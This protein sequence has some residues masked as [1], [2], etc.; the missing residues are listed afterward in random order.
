MLELHD[1]AEG[2]T[3]DIPAGIQSADT[4][5]NER[6]HMRKFSWLGIYLDPNLDLFDSYDIYKDFLD[7]SS[8]TA[9]IAHDLDKLDI[10]IQGSSILKSDAICNRERIE[11]L[12]N[13]CE[14]LITTDQVRELLP[15]A[16][17]M[18]V[19]AKE[20]FGPSNSSVKNYY[21]SF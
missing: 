17:K 6:K 11:K 7:Q 2:I 9:K 5:E 1:I 19:I 10:V 18:N 3:G 16:K 8:L 4:K 20:S 14:K 13:D 21:F 15:L 12:V